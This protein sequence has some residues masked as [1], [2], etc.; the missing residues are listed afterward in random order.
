MQ[1]T[2]FPISEVKILGKYVYHIFRQ[3]KNQT[4]KFGQ[5]IEHNMRNI[6]GEKS[7]SKCGGGNI[8]ILFPKKYIGYISGS[9]A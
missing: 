9:I 5:L 8:Q 2:D 3:W 4:M 7:Y 6:C 1:Y